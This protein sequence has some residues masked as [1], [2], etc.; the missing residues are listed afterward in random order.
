MAERSWVL[1]SRSGEGAARVEYHMRRPALPGCSSAVGRLRERG[2]GELR[3]WAQQ[4]RSL[5]HDAC[6]LGVGI[7]RPIQPHGTG[8][9]GRSIL[10]YY[11]TL[12]VI[13]LVVLHRWLI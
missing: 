9:N 1:G 13:Q 10:V 11:L 3:R 2:R 5:Q 4:Q 12:Y 6:D 8:L 7:R